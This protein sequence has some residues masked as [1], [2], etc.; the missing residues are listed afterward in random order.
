M[1]RAVIPALLVATLLT[2]CG[3]QTSPSNTGAPSVAS[4]VP[5]PPASAPPSASP[6]EPPETPPTAGIH[7]GSLV[8]TLVKD[9]GI[10]NEPRMDGTRLGTLPADEIAFV[11]D[12]PVTADGHTPAGIGLTMP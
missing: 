7:A 3:A 12:G 8:V 9:L 2:A 6:S 1:A 4:M 5:T 11:V 10:R